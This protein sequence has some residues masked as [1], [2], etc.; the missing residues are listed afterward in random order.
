ML[1][2]TSSQLEEVVMAPVKAGEDE[3]SLSMESMTLSGGSELRFYHNG[4]KVAEVQL[5]RK[6]T[7]CINPE[8]LEL[9]QV[10]CPL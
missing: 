1:S 8:L 10:A 7:D 9:G 6:M 3:M 5:P 4:M 2:Q